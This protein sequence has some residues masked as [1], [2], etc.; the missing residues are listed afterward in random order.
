MQHGSIRARNE[1]RKNFPTKFSEAV[2]TIK[3]MRQKAATFLT[4]DETTPY[5]VEFFDSIPGLDPSA[6]A[7]LCQPGVKRLHQA[8]Y[9]GADLVCRK[10]VEN[11]HTTIDAVNSRGETALHYATRNGQSWVVQY[12]LGKG[13]N[14]NAQ[15]DHGAGALHM[16]FCSYDTETML[17]LL[18]ER[19]ANP[20]LSSSG[21]LDQLPDRSD[22][23]MVGIGTP[24][25]LSIRCEYLGAALVLLKYGANPNHKVEFAGSAL[26]VGL[27][28]H[29]MA[30]LD[31]LMPWAIKNVENLPV[32]HELY[33]SLVGFYAQP[34]YRYLY[35]GDEKSLRFILP[36]ME[37]L[38]RYGLAADERVLLSWAMDAD[39]CEV[40]DYYLNKFFSMGEHMLQPFRDP[41]VSDTG[42]PSNSQDFPLSPDLKDLLSVVI[43]ISSK[44][45]VQI[46]LRYTKKPLSSC[47]NFGYPFLCQ[48]GFRQTEPREYLDEIVSWLIE[49]GV[50]VKATGAVRGGP[51]Q[52][53]VVWNNSNLADVLLDYELSF[54]EVQAAMQS[55]VMKGNSL[56]AER[57]MRSIFRKYPQILTLQLPKQEFD[58][59]HLVTERF[60]PNYL[61]AICSRPEFSQQKNL[62]AGILR[63]AIQ[64]TKQQ[65]GGRLALKERLS[66][67][68]FLLMTPLH[69]TAKNANVEA[70]QI[71][72]EEGANINAYSI[73]P[74]KGFDIDTSTFTCTSD[75]SGLNDNQKN[76]LLANSGPTPLDEA[77]DR[78]WEMSLYQWLSSDQNL[79]MEFRLAGGANKE[80]DEY[81]ER[82]QTMINFL[83]A[84]GAKTRCELF[85]QP[86]SRQRERNARLKDSRK[87]YKKKN[88]Q[89]PSSDTSRR[90]FRFWGAACAL[91]SAQMT[92]REFPDLS[93]RVEPTRPRYSKLFA[94]SISQFLR[95]LSST[96]ELLD[97]ERRAGIESELSGYR[98]WAQKIHLEEGELDEIA[99]IPSPSLS[100]VLSASIFVSLREIVLTLRYIEELLAEP[101]TY[102]E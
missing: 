21:T 96:S 50:D 78:D 15:R 90:I 30:I 82:T 40:A 44:E 55:C 80:E 37:C 61:R 74:A 29:S 36:A 17:S 3:E 14:I 86:E 16:A 46:V 102:I 32:V 23:C 42:E 100:M 35:W 33:S 91:H 89:R 94:D 11:D 10:L 1:L 34:M 73:Y 39:D 88:E 81:E 49:A 93:T 99:D 19:G 57:I 71:L 47:N 59:F 7:V 9:L 54:K 95:I 22:F 66:E 77:Y 98:T 24:L 48:V 45:M 60:D 26:R 58:V 67:F 92:L 53:A 97:D 84:N 41:R 68:G 6:K 13:A 65:P 38:K 51:L 52:N 79:L 87:L 25:H 31:F 8:A 85:G 75:L 28:M 20:E 43:S 4:A 5:A 64:C 63:E 62:H 12:L 27:Q 76:W 2:A 72:L 70:A 56:T 101:Q 69:Y 18:L 83:K